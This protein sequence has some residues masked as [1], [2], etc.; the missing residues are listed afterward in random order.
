MWNKYLYAF[1]NPLASVDPDGKW[2]FYI[3][4]AIDEAVFAG[5]LTSRQIAVIEH[6]SYLMDFGDSGHQQDPAR[7]NEHGMA[8]P[9]QSTDTAWNGI[10]AWVGRAFTNAYNS[11]GD[12][13]LGYFADGAH[14]VQD[15]GSPAHTDSA[16]NP[17]TW[18]G[19]FIEGI[20][21]IL[22][23]TSPEDSWLGIGNSIRNTVDLYSELHPD[24]AAAQGGAGNWA[25][26]AITSF[27]SNYYAG[28][29]Q[30]RG[31]DPLTNANNEDAA[32]Q[33]ALGNR[34]ACD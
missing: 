9:G 32:R 1:S 24:E 21:H 4:D 23:E 12:T 30:S 5:V 3:H 15:L 2:P 22:H 20:V 11:W 8:V 13:S 34:A 6:E 25:D 7:A 16:G 10:S 17:I 19:G 33:C 27:V 28:M 31:V 18:G 26:R 29:T 14:T